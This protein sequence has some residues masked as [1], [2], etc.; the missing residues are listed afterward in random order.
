MNKPPARGRTPYS[1]G[2]QVGP[3]AFP[4]TTPPAW[5][6]LDG[7]AG[8]SASPAPRAPHGDCPGRPGSSGLAAHASGSVL[9]PGGARRAPNSPP[10]G[11]RGPPG[12]QARSLPAA[13]RR[14]AEFTY[15]LTGP[16][17]TSENRD[18]RTQCPAPGGRSL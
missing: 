4:R 17:P 6:I 10:D 12:G 7:W 1:Q 8:P 18:S 3:A 14:P 2:A 15:K 5:R 13:V 9:R 11:L 16:A